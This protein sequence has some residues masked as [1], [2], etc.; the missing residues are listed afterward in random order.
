ME[1][2]QEAMKKCFLMNAQ[3]KAS[4]GAQLSKA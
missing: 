1:D 4:Q 2:A 3:E